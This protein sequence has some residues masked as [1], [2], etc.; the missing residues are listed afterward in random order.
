MGTP[1]RIMQLETMIVF[2][3]VLVLAGMVTDNR[4][5]FHGAIALMVCAVFI[6]PVSRRIVGIWL[7]VAHVIAQINNRVILT[8]L[9][10]FFLTPIA[11]LY[12]I[13]NKDPLKIDP[14]RNGSFYTERNHTYDQ[15]DL[16]KMW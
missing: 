6:E 16:R 14:V 1:S 2:S 9:F 8:V 10:Y 7:K 12:R 4:Y 3:L 5:C 11:V 15:A 13:F